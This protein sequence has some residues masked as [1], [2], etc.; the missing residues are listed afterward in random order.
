VLEIAKTD[1]E[2]VFVMQ[3]FV[4]LVPVLQRVRVLLP[5]QVSQWV[6]VLQLVQE[7]QVQL[8]PLVLVVF[9]HVAL[10]LLVHLLKKSKKMMNPKSL[11]YKF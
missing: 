3:E 4:L 2:R 1:H 9:H 7:L 5:V 10:L 6:R 8:Q 11:G